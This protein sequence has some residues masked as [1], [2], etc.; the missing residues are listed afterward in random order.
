VLKLTDIHAYYGTSHVL[1]GVSLEV[2]DGEIVAL[3]GRNGMGKTTTLKTVMGFV[4]PRGGMV[5]FNERQIGGL[6][7]HDVARLGIG[8]VPENRRIFP[9]LTVLE[10][11][12]LGLSNAP[13]I[14]DELRQRNLA[15]VFQHFPILKDKAGQQGRN[16]SGGQQQMLTIAR[17]MMGD[18]RLILMDEPTQGLAP[19]LVR[20]IRDIV[21]ELKGMG[22]TVLLVE[23]NARVALNVAD[24]GYIMEKGK[25]VFAGSAEMLRGSEVAR[26]KLGV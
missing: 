1:Q 4:Q 2:K 24:R 18:T 25:V 5:E 9:G 11:L 17:A 3:L 14:T 6:R 20:E 19:A 16:L 23:Q 7:P 12:E 26:E 13:R 10:N 22:I 21:R 15:R 8:Y